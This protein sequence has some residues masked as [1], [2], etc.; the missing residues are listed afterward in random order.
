MGRGFEV[1]RIS[2]PDAFATV[3]IFAT[4]SGISE[5]FRSKV[6]AMV[7]R[8]AE[9][10]IWSV[11]VARQ[12]VQGLGVYGVTIV[13][14]FSQP[15]DRWKG[16][17]GYVHAAFS[18]AKQ[19]QNPSLTGAVLY[20]HKQMTEVPFGSPLCLSSPGKKQY[21]SEPAVAVIWEMVEKSL[22]VMRRTH[23]SYVRQLHC[24]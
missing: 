18:R 6:Q 2:P 7:D 10:G 16:E 20:G 22:I 15:D 3:V 11:A 13:S 9:C 17:Q 8:F 23:H 12:E 5:D 21:L 1:E 14:V 4:G 19:I 24:L